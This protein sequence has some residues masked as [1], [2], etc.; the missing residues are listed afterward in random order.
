MHRMK[1][2]NETMLKHGNIRKK[3]VHE[4]KKTTQTYLYLSPILIFHY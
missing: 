4:W 2:W 3:R 1:D